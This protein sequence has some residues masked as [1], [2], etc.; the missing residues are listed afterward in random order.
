MVNRLGLSQ[1]LDKH[2]ASLSGGE[3]QRVMIAAS[4]LSDKEIVIL[5]EPSSGLDLLQM[6]A[7]VSLLKELKQQKKVV[8]V[9][10]HDEELLDQACDSIYQLSR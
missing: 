3:Q 9:I 8:I 10:S 2:P 6:Q 5:D 7:L 4:L 1:L